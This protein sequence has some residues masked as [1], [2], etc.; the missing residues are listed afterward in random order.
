MCQYSAKRAFTWA[1]H[2]EKPMRTEVHAHGSIFLCKGM[3]L[4]QV[5][6][7]LRPWLEHLDVETL[8][9]AHSLER[10]E[11]GIV[12]DAQKRTLNHLLDG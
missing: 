7:A 5:E 6:Q 9:D 2:T 11:P 4:N 8:A 3:R 1:G 10:E 12:F